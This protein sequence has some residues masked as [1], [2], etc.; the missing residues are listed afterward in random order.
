MYVVVVIC[1]VPLVSCCRPGSWVWWG[2]F[3]K[4]EQ[5]QRHPL[6]EVLNV[7]VSF[8]MVSLLSVIGLHSFL[9]EWL[10]VMYV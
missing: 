10:Q 4:A 2:S 6:I 5:L 7:L 3:V 9:F 1:I 8:R